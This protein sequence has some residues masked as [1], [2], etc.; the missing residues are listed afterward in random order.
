MASIDE[1]VAAAVE[2]HMQKVAHYIADNAVEASCHSSGSHS[3]RSPSAGV[4]MTV[5][6]EGE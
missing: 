6:G 1:G 4:V 2:A 3:Y 5:S